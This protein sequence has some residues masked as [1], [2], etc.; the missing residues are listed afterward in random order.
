[1][2]LQDSSNYSQDL[3]ELCYLGA[4]HDSNIF[5]AFKSGN[6]ELKKKK[7]ASPLMPINFSFTIHGISGI[8]RGDMFKVNGIP[9]IYE[10]GFFQ[11]L[12]VK[13][14]LEGMSWKTEVTG[15]YR[16]NK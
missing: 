7:K 3:F 14:T 9:T 16:N 6:D 10:N 2:N 11:V 1:V 8:R 12:S 13:H 15:G 4:F 5:S